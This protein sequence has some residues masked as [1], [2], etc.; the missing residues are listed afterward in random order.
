LKPQTSNLPQSVHLCDF[1][2]AENAVRNTDLEQQMRII[3]DVVVMGRQ[4]RKDND[5]KVRQPLRRLDVVSHDSELLNQV[6]EL[7]EIIAEELNVREVVFGDDDSDLATLHAKANFKTLGP[8]FG[9]Q[10]KEIARVISS[11][12]EEELKKV[13]VGESIS[14]DL[15]G[16]SIELTPEDIFVEHTPKEGLAVQT[17]GALVVALDLELDDDLIREGLAREL[18]KEVQQLRKTSGLDV[19]DRIHLKLSS[20]DAVCEAVAAY[21]DYIQAEVLAL[22]VETGAVEGEPVDLNGHACT[23]SVKKA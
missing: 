19:T 23:I 18:V 21:T 7:K 13:A 12:S 4:L 22:S 15:D 14:I 9:K 6:G 5:A 2:T 3:M 1:P 10:M 8:K 17:Q 20:D 11:L 16:T